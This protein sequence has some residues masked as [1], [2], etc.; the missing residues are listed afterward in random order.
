ML[1]IILNFNPYSTLRLNLFFR[2]HLV[3]S[4]TSSIVESPRKSENEK[5]WG[6]K[7]GTR[8]SLKKRNNEIFEKYTCGTKVS[9]LAN[10][11][12][13]SEQ[14]IRKIIS[15]ERKLSS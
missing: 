11:Y 12:F 7:N 3:S 8:D 6:E 13:L 2:G 14:S 5:A 10:E 1:S 15:R 9:K 4:F